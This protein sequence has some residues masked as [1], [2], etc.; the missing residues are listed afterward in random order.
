MENVIIL[1]GQAAENK[2]E[3][4]RLWSQRPPGF[5]LQLCC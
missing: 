1:M 2:E 3:A 5:E 4:G